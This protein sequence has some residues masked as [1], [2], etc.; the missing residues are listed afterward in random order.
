MLTTGLG[1]CLAT[2]LM[3]VSFHGE[4][5]VCVIVNDKSYCKVM[6]VNSKKSIPTT[7]KAKFQY[8]Q[9]FYE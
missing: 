3:E 6:M 8:K 7:V 9:P 1:L 4:N 2:S 5:K